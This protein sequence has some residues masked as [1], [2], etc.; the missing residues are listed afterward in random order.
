M[1]YDAIIL[2]S[3]QAGMPLAFA[4]AGR[5][6]TVALVEKG[7]I[8]GTCINT[9]CTPT[10]TMV[11]RAQVAHYARNA[12]RWGV[13]TSGVRV[14]L[15]TIVAQKNKVVENAR[16]SQ[17]KGIAK[18][19][20][21]RLY[22]GHAEFSGPHQVKVGDDLLESDRIFINTGARP[23]IP[24]IP[25]LSSS[26]YLTNE[27]IMELVTVP[28]HLLVIG[29]GYVGLEFGQMFSRFGSQVTIIQ[30]AGQIAPR[31]DVEVAA[32]LQ[33]SLEAEGIT[34][35]LDTRTTSVE[36]KDGAVR[37]T[38]EQGGATRAISGTH[39]LVATGRR[40]NADDLALEKAGVQT[41]ENG[42]IHVN[43]KLE[44]TVPGVW[45]LGDVKGGPAFTHISYNDYQ[46]V[47]ANV[48]EGKNLSI[49]N[50]IVPYCV[51]TDPQ[52]GGVGLTERE[53]RGKGYRL[54]IGNVP[55]TRVARA[56]ERDET[57]GLMKLIVNAENDQIL[58]ATILS[59]DGGETVHILYT[60]MLANQPY[61]LLKGAVYIHPTL[62]EG[63]FFLMDAVKPAP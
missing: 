54:K 59:S 17:T 50:R 61:T 5:G 8:G 6:S 3:G 38:I 41:N 55:M 44:T 49:E 18:F 36:R 33:K 30:T 20:S 32:E 53:A 26:G 58:G 13:S 40:P 12:E 63:L 52:L 51:F 21:L 14:N 29:G 43:S 24:E 45:A 15:D 25:G 60:L 46:I 1:K 2:G 23:S 11:A 19:P 39:L 22:R 10:K 31:E 42:S 9:G 35:F 62:A 7:N 34:F 56:I 47:Y 4:L 48:I 57:P 37:L 28:E 16:N 27:T